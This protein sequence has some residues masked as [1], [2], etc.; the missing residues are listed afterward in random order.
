VAALLSG[1]IS[2]AFTGFAGF[3]NVFS[4][5]MVLVGVGMLFK[6]ES[7]MFIA[8]ILCYIVL[9]IWSAY[10]CLMF[11]A[12]AYV[13]AGICAFILGVT[14]FMLYLLNWQGA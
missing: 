12:G 8:K 4:V 9:C 1:N 7:V 14:G 13:I 5:V 6:M 3:V 10:F 2:T 11:F